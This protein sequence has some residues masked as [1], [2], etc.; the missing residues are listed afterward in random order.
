[1]ENFVFVS[2]FDNTLTH[3]DFYKIILDKYMKESGKKLFDEW[4]KTKKIN[5]SELRC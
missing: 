5:N 2:D 3:K 4:K 1:M